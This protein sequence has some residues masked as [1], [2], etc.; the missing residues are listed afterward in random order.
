MSNNIQINGAKGPYDNKVTDASVRY[1]RNA[2]ENHLTYL[3]EPLVNDN[4]NPAPILDFSTNP[5]AID[6]N[7]ENLEYFI[8]ENDNYLKSLPP[9]EYEYRYMPNVVNGQIDKKALL[10]AAYEEMGG[11]KELP[12]EEF[13][14]RYMIDDTM[15]AEPLDINKDGKIDIA[16]YGA[17]ILATDVLSKGTTDVTKVDGTINTKGMNAILEYTKKSNAKLATDLYSNLYHTYNLDKSVDDFN[18]K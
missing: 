4:P 8:E 11:V 1:G 5:Q 9:L 17:N 14:Y 7:I 10:G 2:I 3:E 16:E 12:V 18:Q 6:K 13:E 15:T